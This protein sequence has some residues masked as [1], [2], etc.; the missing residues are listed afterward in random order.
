MTEEKELTFLQHL[1]ILR[2]HLVRCAVAVLICAIAIFIK[3][4]WVFDN[5]IFAPLRS[6]F[7]SYKAMCKLSAITNI[8]D[9]CIQTE[10]HPLQALSAS[11]QF[12]N[13][14]WI[15]IVLGIILASPYIL[16]ELWRFVSPAL[17]DNESNQ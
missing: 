8:K 7:Y 17:K 5:V 6:D 11:E 14:I 12:F 16:W 4:S 2:K 3:A 13:H 1:D 15:S 10:T 9:L